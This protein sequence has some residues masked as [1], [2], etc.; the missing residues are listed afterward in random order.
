MI[1]EDVWSHFGR[2]WAVLIWMA[3][4]GVFIL[5][6]PFYRKSQ[7]KPAG[8]YLAFVVAFAVEMFGIPF[9]MFA[10]GWLFGYT[11]PEGVFWGHTL[12]SYIG[13]RGYY[14]GILTSLAGAVLV[15][16]GW[17]QIHKNYW[18]KES[19]Q[20]RLVTTGIYRYIRHPQY[21]G[22]FMITMGMMMEWATLPLIFLYVLFVVMYY[23]L[24]KREEKDMEKEFGGD[25]VEY[26]KRTRMFVPFVI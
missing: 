17:K 2:W 4:Y 25:Y 21:T 3:I 24:A 20:G 13:F 19:G 6:V 10:I 12:G 26:R 5:F 8:V 15:I 9:S 18:S 1:G 14:L 11:L 22:F 7:V 16:L 23:S